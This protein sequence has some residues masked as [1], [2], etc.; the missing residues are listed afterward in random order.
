MTPHLRSRLENWKFT[1]ALALAG[2]EAAP[3]KPPAA[4]E[5]AA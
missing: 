2:E 1:Q 5:D 4:T 3:A